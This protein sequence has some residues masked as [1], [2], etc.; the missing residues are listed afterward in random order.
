[1]VGGYL[2]PST[3]NKPLGKAVVDG[4]T[5]Q[6]GAPPRHPIVR[7]WEQ[8]TVGAVVFLWHQTVLCRTGQLLFIVRCA[9]TLPSDSAAHYSVGSEPLQSTV[10]LDSRYSAGAPDSPVNY[11]G[12]RL[13]KP[14]SGWFSPVQTWCT[15]HCPVAHRTVQCASPQHTWFLCFFGFG[16][17]TCIFIG[18]C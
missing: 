18:L 12:E 13:K 7:V 9:L 16:S 17:L 15:G 5:G 8:S 10:A 6:S 4:R 1:V 11:S 14:E 2:W 3:T